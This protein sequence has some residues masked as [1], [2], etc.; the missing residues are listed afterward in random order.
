MVLKFDKLKGSSELEVK[1]IEAI[2]LLILKQSS[3]KFNSLSDFIKENIDLKKF[4]DELIRHN[5]YDFIE[6]IYK[7]YREG[8][9]SNNTAN[10][11]V[12]HYLQSKL[13]FCKILYQ[14]YQHLDKIN[15]VIGENYSEYCTAISQIDDTY[16]FANCFE[17]ISK[18]DEIA[19]LKV[20]LN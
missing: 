11:G 8:I 17:D 9:R 5:I 10:F 2:S 1:K 15:P 4:K 20:A 19:S 18:S 13:I 7:C 3:K 14:L 12:S 6:G 16:S